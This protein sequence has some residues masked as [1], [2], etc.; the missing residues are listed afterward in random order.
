M[1]NPGQAVLAIGG[2]VAGYLIPGVGP[3]IGFY[4]GSLA[5]QLLFPTEVPGVSGPRLDD[6]A[7][8]VSTVGAPVPWRFGTIS[9]AG[10]VIW[11]SGLIE[12]VTKNKQGGASFGPSQ[13]TTSYSYTID[14]AVG[15]CESVEF[16]TPAIAGIKRMWF[17]AVCV[18]DK[19]PQLVGESDEDF[20]T[21]L[22]S[23]TQLDEIMVVYLG[24]EDQVPDP[25]IESYED[26]GNGIQ[27]F[28]ELAYIVLTGLPLEK[29]GNRL[30]NIRIETY[31]E[32]TTDEE[33]CSALSPGHLERWQYMLDPSVMDPRN[34]DNVHFYKSTECDGGTPTLSFDAAL[35][36]AEDCYGC[37]PVIGEIPQAGDSIYI[38]G[39]SYSTT[40]NYIQPC[41]SEEPSAPSLSFDAVVVQIQ[42]NFIHDNQG[43]GGPGVDTGNACQDYWDTVG[44]KY[45]PPVYQSAGQASG[46]YMATDDDDTAGAR[47]LVEGCTR[48]DG[49]GDCNDPELF[50][51]YAL[52]DAQLAVQRSIVPDPCLGG[53]PIPT[54]PGFCIVNGVVTRA[55]T[56]TRIEGAVGE[57]K[58]L[59]EYQ[60]TGPF[61][62]VTSYPVGPAL[63]N[64]HVDFN[65]QTFW[66]QAYTDAL[67]AGTYGIEPGWTYGVEYPEHMDYIYSSSCAGEVIDTECA[68]IANIIGRILRRAGMANEDFDITTFDPIEDCPL[69]YAVFT[70]TPVSDCIKPLLVY[71]HADAVESQ[72]VL[73]FVKRGGASAATLEAN[74]LAVHGTGQQRPSAIQTRRVLE[75]SLPRLL[76]LSYLS[77]DRDYEV[78]Q[79][80]KSR[81]ATEATEEMDISLPIVMTDD[82]AKQIV[83]TMLY[84]FWV[85][86]TSYS[87]SVPRKHLDLEPTDVIIVPSD[88]EFQRMRIISAVYST[89]GVYTLECAKDDD[90]TFSSSAVGGAP[91]GSGGSGGGASSGLICPSEV[92]LLDLPSL[93]PQD[94]DAGYYMASRGLCAGNR[95][96]QLYRSSDAGDTYQ[97]VGNN[98]TD[99]TIGTLLAGFDFEP[100]SFQIAVIELR[101]GGPLASTTALGLQ[102]GANLFAIGAD[103][104][105]VLGQF[106]TAA[107]DSSNIWAISDITL[108]LF[109]TDE[110]IDSIVAGDDFILMNYD[111]IVRI[112]E[113]P[114]A[115]GIQKDFKIVSCGQSLDD[116]SAFQFTTQGLSYQPQTIT[117]VISVT[118]CDPPDD[119]ANGDSYYLPCTGCTLTAEWA[120]HC[121]T[122]ATW[123]DQANT[124]IY[125]TPSPGTIIHVQDQA[126]TPDE[127][128]TIPSA[129][130]NVLLPAPWQNKIE[131]FE[132]DVSL[133]DPGEVVEVNFAENI[134]A[135]IDSSG[136]LNVSVDNSVATV[137]S[138]KN[139]VRVATTA[140]G[141]L[142]TSFENGDTVDGVILATGDRILIKNQSAGAENGIYTVNVSGAPTRSTDADI[143]T[144]L[145]G[146]ACFVSEGTTNADKLFLCTTN[147]PITLGVTALTF[148]ELTTGGSPLTTKGDLYTRNSTVD[149]RLPV[150]SNGDTVIADS[151]ETV[152]LRW[153]V[154]GIP[155]N[156]QTGNYTIT[157]NDNG[158]AID[159][160][161]GAG[162]GDT[163]T[164]DSN[165]NLALPVGFTFSVFNMDTNT[166]SVAITTDT[167]RRA[168]LG[169]T[170]T[171]SIPQY[172]CATFRKVAT[173]TWL[174]FGVGAS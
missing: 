35:A 83:E 26:E 136:R 106:G 11:S 161:S 104:R 138:W 87:L 127:Y 69:G 135:S 153:G 115:I 73:K 99:S 109:G 145:V 165:A 7:V 61:G 15:I 20:A 131:W 116:V 146:A 129:S 22:A 126:E 50:N 36:A 44:G 141:T 86:R 63:H 21:R 97:F 4:V 24:T 112:Q 88:G 118:T 48:V 1:A 95:C 159:H 56:W 143:G 3:L 23:T 160:A 124:W 71:A 12:H 113:T 163:Y 173:T 25:T 91:S 59:R 132:D 14:V 27:A 172:C 64:D 5:G 31:E 70:Q 139:S 76:R 123:S 13:T 45:Q 43:C 8:Q 54:A 142:A 68:L 39:W 82:K 174:W 78:G 128:Q 110:F 107:L 40:P 117:D 122:I 84:D 102:S 96:S 10:N 90:G 169:T 140:A 19:R 100:S 58:A 72:T 93:R 166:V 120:G 30:P 17:D 125:S 167:L 170:G 38:K 9:G 18:Y 134:T 60:H 55:V 49:R 101:S 57:W 46:Y 155:S 67:A 85:T 157:A 150:G 114:A 2:A 92:I 121:G 32:G 53:T 111:D 164:I 130:D 41:D 119:P 75:S 33:D 47:A 34:P 79:Q 133:A 144:E 62:E 52:F 98:D 151:A 158:R 51:K 28:R 77:P 16:D 66:E 148:T 65:N 154:P 149:D 137:L 80:E 74:D 156:A 89:V 162:A 94:T 105:W 103:G 168:L 152:G 42:I 37:R 147:A 29:W 81:T 108:G 6:L 171:V